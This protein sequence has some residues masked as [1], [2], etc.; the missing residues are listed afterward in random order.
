MLRR[1][2]LAA[3]VTVSLGLAAGV[4]QPAERWDSSW[5]EAE[6]RQ[7]LDLFWASETEFT[8]TE[9]ADGYAI[10]FPSLT[11]SLPVATIEFSEFVFTLSPEDD[12]RTAFDIEAVSPTMTI[13]DAGGLTVARGGFT[14]FSIAGVWSSRFREP[15]STIAT[16][17]GFTLAMPEERSELSVGT[18]RI[19]QEMVQAENGRWDNEEVVEI[20]D[21]EVIQFGRREAAIG[22]VSMREELRGYDVEA[23][24]AFRHRHDTGLIPVPMDPAFFANPDAALPLFVDLLDTTVGIF[25][26]AH[27]VVTL[28]DMVGPPG[29]GDLRRIDNLSLAIGYED[30][31]SDAGAVSVDLRFGGLTVDDLAEPPPPPLN[32]YVPS[33]IRLAVAIEQLPID[34]MLRTIVTSLRGAPDPM[35][36]GAVVGPQLVILLLRQDVTVRMRDLTIE[37]A[38]GAMRGSA[39]VQL[40]P[41]SALGTTAR[42]EF[43]VVGLDRLIDLMQRMGAPDQDIAGLSFLQAIGRAG[44]PDNGRSVL[45]YTFEQ[46]AAGDIRLNDMDLWPL[47]AAGGFN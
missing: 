20:G 26:D 36:G 9:T 5:L 27:V 13:S 33:Q 39:V 28:E 4:A 38:E 25:Q 3:S 2:L 6:T 7:M 34:S 41:M 31:D 21:V 23:M 17:D 22:A 12:D 1:T 11:I 10:R 15:L 43:T 8:I 30:F 47:L 35:V 45:H 18:I 32:G 46:T 24:A 19:R 16:M 37:A 14:E 29:E 40:D 42:A 44:D